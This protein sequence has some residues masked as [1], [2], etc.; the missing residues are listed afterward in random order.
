MTRFGKLVLIGVLAGTLGLIGC[1]DDDNGG[2][3]G[4]GGNAGTGGTAGSG[5]DG[6]TGGDDGVVCGEGESIDD[7][8]MTGNGSVTCDGLGVITVPIGVTLAAKADG[9]IEGATDVD[10]RVQF[11]IDEDTVG[12][13]G[14]LVQQ[15]LIGESSADIDEVGGDS[16]TNV[17]ATVPCTADFTVDTDDNGEPGP[18]VVT[19]PAVVASWTAADGSI[20]LEAVDMTF[21]I[22]QPVPLTL[23]TSGAEPACTWIEQP[24]VTL[25]A[26]PM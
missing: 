6:G 1:G 19:T 26:A 13:L 2:S 22:I 25:D 9:P 20:V 18:V 11:T 15:A 14:A 4:N 5:G 21:A 10:V 3:A 17:P 8:Y 23:S 16:A 7:S 24:T 12:E